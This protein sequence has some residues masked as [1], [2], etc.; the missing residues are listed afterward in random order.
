MFQTPYGRLEI[1]R[2][3]DAVGE[4]TDWLVRARQ[5]KVDSALTIVVAD[6]EDVLRSKE[7]AGREKDLAALAQMRADFEDAGSL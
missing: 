6:P 5:V 2:R 3:A 1:V 7:A 4:Y